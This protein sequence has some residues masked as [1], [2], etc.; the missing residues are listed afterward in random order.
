MTKSGRNVGWR[1]SPPLFAAPDTLALK[2]LTSLP[3]NWHA[4]ADEKIPA[5]NVSN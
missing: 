3:R 1:T 5:V 2:R 4:I